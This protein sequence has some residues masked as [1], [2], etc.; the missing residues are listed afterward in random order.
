[1]INGTSP[2]PVVTTVPPAVTPADLEAW[3]TLD[4]KASGILVYCVD[5]SLYHIL[6]NT[7]PNTA[8][9]KYAALKAA[10]GTPSQALVF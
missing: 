9:G 1:M 7:T 8:A 5:E 4:D 10:Y 2:R 3:V 6:E